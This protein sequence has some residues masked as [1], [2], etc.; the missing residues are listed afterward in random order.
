MTPDPSFW[1]GIGLSLQKS[2]GD[3]LALLIAAVVVVIAAAK[4]VVPQWRLDRDSSRDLERKRFELEAKRQEDEQ[5]IQTERIRMQQRQLDIQ[6]QLTR[7]VDSQ[8][9]SVD[10]LVSQTRELNIR[11]DSSQDRSREMGETV[12]RIDRKT[13]AIEDLSSAV[14]EIRDILKIGGTD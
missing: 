13:D 5:R 9:A 7:S 8:T 6:E 4:L 12:D 11:L 3:I 14:G 1:E 2:S 10:N